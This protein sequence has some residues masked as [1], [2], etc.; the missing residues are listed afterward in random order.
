MTHT[1]KMDMQRS[2]LPLKLF[3][4]RCTECGCLQI[5]RGGVD[6]PSVYRPRG[7]GRNPFA[8]LDHEP[9]CPGHGDESEA[10]IL[11]DAHAD[12]TRAGD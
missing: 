11:A 3:V 7:A 6:A 2:R 10:A 5:K 9:R 8:T 1:W 4:W 12:G